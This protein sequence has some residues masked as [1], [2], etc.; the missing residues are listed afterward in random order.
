MENVFTASQAIENASQLFWHEI[1]LI[2]NMITP[3]VHQQNVIQLVH[4]SKQWR[5]IFLP[6]HMT[7]KCV[8]YAT[9]E[10][11]PPFKKVWQIILLHFK[12]I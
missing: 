8:Y 6:I 11:H 7:K 4:Y 1:I 12:T 2:Q 5:I 9:L 10:S 3:I